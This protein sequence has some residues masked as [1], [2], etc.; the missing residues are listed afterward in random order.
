MIYSWRDPGR[1]RREHRRHLDFYDLPA[2]RL[3]TVTKL[4]M[5]N[6]DVNHSITMNY[7]S[8]IV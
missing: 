8:V 3:K 1:V 5:K 7:N 4:F 2:S 6:G